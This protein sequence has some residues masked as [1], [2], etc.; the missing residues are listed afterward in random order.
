MLTLEQYIRESVLSRAEADLFLDPG[1]PSW[2]RFN[3]E[4]GYTLGNYMPR[5]GMDNSYTIS[6][7]ADNTGRRACLYRNKPCRINTYGNS[8]TQCH[9]VSDG[10]TWQEYLAAHFGEPLNNF[11]MGGYGVYQAYRRMLNIEKTADQ[12]PNII[13]YIWGDDHHRSL[14]RCRHVLTYRHWQHTRNGEMFHGNF[15]SHVE[16]DLNTGRIKEKPQLCPTPDS[17]YRMCD[18]EFMYKNCRDDLMLQLRLYLRDDIRNIDWDKISR[19]AAIL[20]VALDPKAKKDTV[21][22]QLKRL[23][24][25][26]AFRAT[27]FIL[28]RLRTFCADKR[29]K[30]LLICFDPEVTW[31]L[32][33][34]KPRYDQEFIDWLEHNSFD[35]FD[36]NLIHRE[37]YKKFNLSL[38]DYRKR[39]FVGHYN[40]AGNHFFAF[41]IKDKLINWLNP[42]PVTYR[43]LNNRQSINFKGYL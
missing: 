15:W 11:G 37:D 36:M 23:S 25:S 24:D 41:S 4:T 27:A 19:L 32:I 22:R 13:F 6:T 12:A 40:P 18:P 9:Q 14:M 30:L 10:E 28:E 26:Y 39:Y 34:G 20:G 16:M 2:A 31:S 35:Y 7:A 5:D 8:F 29:K 21:K 33:K 43:K 38:A 1:Q 42:A 3:P 17:L